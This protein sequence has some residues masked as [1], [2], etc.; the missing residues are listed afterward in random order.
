MEYTRLNPTDLK[1]TVN[2][3]DIVIGPAVTA[4]DVQLVTKHIAD[5]AVVKNV[6]RFYGPGEYEAQGI[7][8][9]GVAAGADDIS[10]QLMC[11]GIAVAALSIADV[12]ALTD[13]VVDHLHPAHVL[14]LWIGSSTVQEFTTLMSRFESSIIIPVS[15]PIELAEV[16]K[17]LQLKA[18][19]TQRLKIGAKDMGTELR[20]LIDLQV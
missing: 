13:E 14:C 8:I 7:M 3:I 20:R 2:Q 19:S 4:G 16:E 6:R 17:E 1:I 10:Y 12:S 15:L 5:T 11:D 18:E 9:D